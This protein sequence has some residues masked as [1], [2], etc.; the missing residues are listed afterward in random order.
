L[1][2]RVCAALGHRRAFTV[3]LVGFAHASGLG[4]AAEAAGTLIAA[5]AAQGVFAAL[6][7]P[8]ALSLLT[9]TFTEAR[10]RG[11]AFGVFAGVG[12]G[13][14]AL[15]VVAGGLLTQYADWRW[16]L[17]INLPMAALALLG[18]PLIARDR[19]AGNL[20]DLDVPG[21]VLSATGFTA[22]VYGFTRAESAGWTDP[23][24]LALLAGG[25][26]RLAAFAVVQLRTRHPLLPPRIP[27]HR[28]RATAL[29]SVA[30]MFLAMFGFYLFVSYYTQTVLGYTAVQAGLTLLVNAVAAIAGSTLL[31]RLRLAP[32][33][34]I[35][36]SLLIA[37]AG[38]L[39]LTSL[40]A[41][42]TG[43]FAAHLL[44]AQ[45][46]TGLGLGCLLAAAANLVTAD[47]AGPEEAG[48]ASAAYN[49]VQQLGAALGTALL[50]SIALG[51]TAARLD[52]GT[53]ATTATVD[54]YA[55]A[56]WTAFG[57]LAAAALAVL[58]LSRKT[59]A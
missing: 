54:G 7:A 20:R 59:R 46:L 57:V 31:A 10:E 33:T 15:G 58:A 48:I 25:A 23:P 30:L 53:D 44:P 50:N 36:G 39:V 38:M 22:L 37:A 32:G 12:A 43:A 35:A 49:A 45:I 21:V 24:V 9:L 41:D 47:V 17:Y 28:A 11:R 16:C 4:G 52:R 34:L 8:A 1:G 14:A 3:G 27:A 55:V 13:G 51:V 40:D 26:A 42:G 6:L 2:G 56:M 29:I 18:T 5:R 19:P